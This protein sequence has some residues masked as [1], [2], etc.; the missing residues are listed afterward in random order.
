[1]PEVWIWRGSGQPSCRSTASGRVQTTNQCDGGAVYRST[2]HSTSTDT[3]VA[4]PVTSWQTRPA[5]RCC[6]RSGRLP[7]QQDRG[8]LDPPCRFR[9]LKPR[10]RTTPDEDAQT[11][12][13]HTEGIVPDT[14]TNRGGTVTHTKTGDSGDRYSPQTPDLTARHV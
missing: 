1:M 3:A 13:V 6:G 11:G 10:R 14:V 5:D 9:R 4:P 2:P 8:P 7:H 12:D